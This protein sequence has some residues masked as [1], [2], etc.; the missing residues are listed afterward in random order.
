MSIKTSFSFGVVRRKRFMALL[1]DRS[2]SMAR[3]WPCVVQSVE[4][5]L[6]PQLLSDTDLILKIVVYAVEASIIDAPAPDKIG[7]FIQSLRFTHKP[8]NQRTVT[9]TCKNTYQVKRYSALLSVPSQMYLM[10]LF[11]MVLYLVSTKRTLMYRFSFSRMARI[12]A[13]RM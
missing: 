5:I 8:T 4:S 7:D 2:G 10:T 1:L 13:S 12:R 9:L 11:P 3:D 6:A